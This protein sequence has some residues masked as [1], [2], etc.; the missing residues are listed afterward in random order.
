MIRK[1]NSVGT[2]TLTMSLPAEWVKKNRLEK[3]DLLYVSDEKDGSLKLG[4]KEPKE[5]HLKKG[6]SSEGLTL[7]LRKLIAGHYKAGYDELEIHYSS[8]AELDRIQTLLEYTCI[9]Y[10]IMNITKKTITI[11]SV[12]KIM[13]EEFDEIYRKIFTV[14]LG[15]GHELQ[16]AIRSKDIEKVK[17]TIIRHKLVNRY[18]DFCRRTI[19]KFPARFPKAGPR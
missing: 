15:I 8:T 18:A 6:L 13:S 12:S 16:D 9:G 5:D 10:E 14:I 4:I 2:G 17:S 19:N 3:G 11:K 7:Y 1:V